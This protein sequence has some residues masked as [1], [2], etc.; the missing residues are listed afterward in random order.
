[1]SIFHNTSIAFPT[2]RRAVVTPSLTEYSHQDL[3]SDFIWFQLL[4][5]VLLRMS[6][7]GVAAAF[8][9]LIATCRK[10]YANNTN[11]SKCVDDLEE[12]YH[13]GCAIYIYTRDTFVYRMLNS[14][15]RRHDIPVLYKFCFLIRDMYNQLKVQ[16]SLFK[17]PLFHVYRGQLMSNEELEKLRANRGRYV[18]MNSFFSTSLNREQTLNMYTGINAPNNRTEHNVLFEIEVDTRLEGVRPFAAISDRS[19]FEGTEEEV[20]F[21]IGSLFKISDVTYHEDTKIWI[22]QLV[23]ASADVFELKPLFNA[24]KRQ[25]GEET[26]LLSLANVYLIM[27]KYKEAEEYYQSFLNSLSENDPNFS[28]CYAG[29]GNIA[30]VQSNFEEA[31]RNYAKALE[32]E[33]KLLPDTNANCIAAAHMNLGNVLTEKK[34]Y[35]KALENYFEALNLYSTLDKQLNVADVQLNI[36]NVYFDQNNFQMALSYYSESE[37]IRMACL[38]DNHPDIATVLYNIGTVE[39]E[40]GSDFECLAMNHLHDALSIQLISVPN[41]PQTAQTHLTIGIGDVHI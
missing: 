10:Q 17:L 3:D 37:K 8:K 21:M 19:A 24:M 34:N 38:T 32:L 11:D 12:F 14:A 27:G 2:S 6:E 1:M 23:L 13:P 25:I 18:S 20:L 31:H 26:A 29:L 22:V 16:Q 40:M 41:H 4:V 39:M 15:L 9:E 36:G 7:D 30:L 33:K 28:R 5:E 35:D